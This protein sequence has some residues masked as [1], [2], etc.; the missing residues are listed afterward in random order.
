MLPLN[1]EIE[2]KAKA[3]EK[4]REVGTLAAIN[5]TASSPSAEN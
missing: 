5:Y 4:S 2:A 3:Q 1:M